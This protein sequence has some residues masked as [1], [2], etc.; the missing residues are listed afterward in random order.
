MNNVMGAGFHAF[1]E[2]FAASVKS[3]ASKLIEAF[4]MSG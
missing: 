1:H 3:D 2:P 4:K